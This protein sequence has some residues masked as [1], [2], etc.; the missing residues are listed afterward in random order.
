MMMMMLVD[1]HEV[2]LAMAQDNKVGI[3]Q[4]LMMTDFMSPN[5]IKFDK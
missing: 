4:L 5:S 3:I 2:R 1:T